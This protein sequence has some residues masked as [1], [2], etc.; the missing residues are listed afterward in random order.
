MSKMTEQ[1]KRN[2]Y[3]FR[4]RKSTKGVDLSTEEKQRQAMMGKIPCMSFVSIC[5]P[6]AHVVTMLQSIIKSGLK[7]RK[8]IAKE[9]GVR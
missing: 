5:F 2:N 9:N 4:F 1:P 7:T 8:Q 6:D 3:P